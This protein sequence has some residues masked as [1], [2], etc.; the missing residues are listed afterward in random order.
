[1]STMRE[2]FLQMG[3]APLAPSPEEF[4]AEIRDAVA[5]WPAIVETAGVSR[6]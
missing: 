1:M 2:R 3:M 6:R 5:R 4:A